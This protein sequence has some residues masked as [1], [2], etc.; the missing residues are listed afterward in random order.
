MQAARY[1]VMGM[2]LALTW[3]GFAAAQP[4]PTS[5]MS[6]EDYRAAA[7]TIEIEF[8][9]ANRNCNYFSGNAN[10]ICVSEAK[11]K[12]LMRMAELA[13]QYQPSPQ[14]WYEYQVVK[15]ETDYAT[16]M[17][18]CDDLTRDDKEFC[19]LEARADRARRL[20][21]AKAKWRAVNPGSLA[22]DVADAAARKEADQQ[23]ANYEAAK[24][25]CVQLVGGAQDLCI[26]KVRITYGRK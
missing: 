21:T 4:A 8:K 2:I 13:Y 14:T 16:A 23:D 24:Q 12:M 19:V 3:T 7:L 17:E 26:D 1:T 15:L 18:G 5:R 25:M 6:K 20:A 10:D 22:H 11:G 9:T